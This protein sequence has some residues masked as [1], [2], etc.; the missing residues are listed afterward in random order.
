MIKIFLVKFLKETLLLLL[1]GPVVQS[2][3]S[4]KAEKHVPMA[5][6]KFGFK[7]PATL[8]ERRQ[9]GYSFGNPTSGAGWG[10]GMK[11]PAGPY[12]NVTPFARR[13]DFALLNPAIVTMLAERP[14]S[15]FYHLEIFIS[16]KKL[17]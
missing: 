3:T 15:I 5:W 13:R 8:G 10:S 6:V 17:L 7:L 14:A 9:V 16:L 4:K 1:Q 12:S 2:G 11:V